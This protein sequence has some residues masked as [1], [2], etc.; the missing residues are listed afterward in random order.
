MNLLL[1]YDTCYYSD[2]LSRDKWRSSIIK[3]F[4]DVYNINVYEII[5][6][7]ND[8]DFNFK[9]NYWIKMGI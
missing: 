9:K 1:L 8:F 6:K 3:E 4:E 7:P 2:N 5:Y